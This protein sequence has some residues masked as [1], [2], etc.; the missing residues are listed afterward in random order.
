M[1]VWSTNMYGSE[2]WTISRE[3]RNKLKAAEMWFYRRMLRVSWRDRV[4]NEEVLRRALLRELRGRQMNFLSHV[5]RSEKT[6]HLCLTGRIEGGGGE[7][8]TESEV[9]GC[10]SGGLGG[11]LDCKLVDTA[12]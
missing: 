3:M 4:T 1:C 8:E 2:S 5:I 11:G 12:G 7:G 9:L 10:H 6:E